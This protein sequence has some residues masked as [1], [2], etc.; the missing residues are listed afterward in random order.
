MARSG[1]DKYLARN[2]ERKSRPQIFIWARYSRMKYKNIWARSTH[3]ADGSEAPPASAQV[4][5]KENIRGKNWA[6][7]YS[8]FR[9]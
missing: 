5:R 8:N 4:R 2:S 9:L 7:I 3:D 1:P 6:L